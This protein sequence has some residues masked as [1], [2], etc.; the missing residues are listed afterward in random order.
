MAAPQAGNSVHVLLSQ[1]DHVGTQVLRSPPSA[2]P[3]NIG[4]Q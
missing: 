2:H 3:G 1:P 4:H